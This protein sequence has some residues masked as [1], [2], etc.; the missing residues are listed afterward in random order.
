VGSDLDLIAVVESSEKPMERRALGWR[1]EDL[2]VPAEL[3]VYT[4]PEWDAFRV[5]GSRFARMLERECIWLWH[6][7]SR[8]AG[9]GVS[10]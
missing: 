7:T 2:P 4:L 8:S 9:P 3:L 6:A 10:S 5:G 1:L